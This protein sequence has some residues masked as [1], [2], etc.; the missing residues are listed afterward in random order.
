MRRCRPGVPML[1]P[2]GDEAV[3]MVL[4]E[5]QPGYSLDGPNGA[6]RLLSM[7]MTHLLT[8]PQAA[9]ALGVSRQA[10]HQWIAAGRLPAERCGRSWLVRRV[11][12]VRPDWRK[13]GPKVKAPAPI[14][15]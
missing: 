4:V 1:S 3:P 11:D 8:I 12:L 6:G 10:V 14:G 13:R 7:S 5:A 2:I 9:T 15:V